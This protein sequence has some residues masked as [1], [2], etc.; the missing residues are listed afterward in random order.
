MGFAR[1]GLGSLSEAIILANSWS[2][3]VE[4]IDF[5]IK[6]TEKREREYNKILRECMC[7][8]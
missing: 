1:F 3:A 6:Q 4:G 2:L 7:E 5:P 8:N